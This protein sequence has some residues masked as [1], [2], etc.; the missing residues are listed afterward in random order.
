V[1][2]AFKQ[3]DGSTS[4]RYGGT[5]LGLSISRELGHLLGGLIEL[6]S[7]P[8]VGSTF[9]LLLPLD[10]ENPQA[11]ALPPPPAS[12]RP[13][14]STTASLVRKA[15]FSGHCVMVVERDVG[16]LLE[17][18]PLLEGW[19]LKVMV[20]ADQEEALECLC[21]EEPCS[22]VLLGAGMPEQEGCATIQK[23]RAEA[24]CAALPVIAIGV[25][26]SDP[27]PAAQCRAAGVSGWL[28]RPLDVAQLET[29]LE[30]HLGG[31]APQDHHH[32]AP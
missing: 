7:R 32:T 30:Q 27:G 24:R 31:S 6:E 8:G 21:D 18:T 3:A 4:R 2:E 13:A 17:I 22:L 23:I 12:N 19:G 20:A 25:A 29:T 15:N 26:S 16:A 28:P 5:G 14:P 11:Q 1:F 9:S 10:P